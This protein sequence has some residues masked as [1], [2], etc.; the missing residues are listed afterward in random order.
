VRA[1][2]R[3]CVCVHVCTHAFILRHF[4]CACCVHA[5]YRSCL[6]KQAAGG[7]QK[8]TDLD[9]VIFDVVLHLLRHGAIRGLASRPYHNGL[10]G[11]IRG[12]AGAR[13]GG[14]GCESAGRCPT[15]RGARS[16]RFCL[17]P[18]SRMAAVG[19]SAAYLAGIFG[20][21]RRSVPRGTV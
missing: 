17:W 20:F 21:A 16:S 10:R 5:S 2:V 14:R 6:R 15:R 19:Q 18:T 13:A 11:G 12:W 1:C 3:A 8:L 7:R 9:G 4:W